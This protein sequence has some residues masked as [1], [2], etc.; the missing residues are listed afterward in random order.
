MPLG[1]LFKGRIKVRYGDREEV[2][3]AGEAFYLSPGHVPAAEAG[4]EFVQF[5]PA[6]ELKVV[7]AAMAEAMQTMQRP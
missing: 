3:A 4:S 5:S 1:Y 6:E 2:V 7:E